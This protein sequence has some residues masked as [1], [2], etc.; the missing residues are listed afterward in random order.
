MHLPR[1]TFPSNKIVTVQLALDTAGVD[2]VGP[3]GCGCLSADHC[4]P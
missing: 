4:L 3:L 2:G 1:A